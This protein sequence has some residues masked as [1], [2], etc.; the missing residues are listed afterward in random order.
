[1]PETQ[2]SSNTYAAW[3]TVLVIV[4]GTAAWILTSHKSRTRADQYHGPKDASRDNAR[5]RFT[6]ID[7]EHPVRQPTVPPS[8]DELKSGQ[9]KNFVWRRR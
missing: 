1:M 5:P 4:V 3:Q 8:V 6:R 2:Q 7:R 9:A